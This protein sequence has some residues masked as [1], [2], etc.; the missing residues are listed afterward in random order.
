LIL[1]KCKFPIAETRSLYCDA[2]LADENQSGLR[3]TLAGAKGMKLAGLLLLPA[4]WAIVLTAVSI[5]ASAGQQ[6][7]FVLAGVGVEIIGLI[8]LARAHRVAPEDTR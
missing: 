2:Y 7:G 4:G 8:L 1:A 5:L 6:A 3:L